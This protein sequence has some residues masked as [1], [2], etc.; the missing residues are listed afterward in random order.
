M[1]FEKIETTGQIRSYTRTD[2]GIK[3]AFKDVLFN[4]SARNALDLWMSGD[5]I[6]VRVTVETFQDEL[7]MKVKKPSMDTPAFTP[8]EEAQLARADAKRR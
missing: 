6:E 3:V 1:A 7:P 5:K 4:D 2:D 8:E